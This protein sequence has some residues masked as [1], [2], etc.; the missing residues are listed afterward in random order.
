MSTRVRSHNEWIQPLK[1]TKCPNCG[2]K[3]SAQTDFH[4]RDAAIVAWGEYHAAR[5][6]TIDHFC[7]DCADEAFYAKLKHHIDGCGCAVNIVAR[8]GYCLPEW[9]LSLDEWMHGATPREYPALC[10]V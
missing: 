9:M 5:W 6:R 10:T 4:G 8:S 7:V 3:H 1:K 2:A